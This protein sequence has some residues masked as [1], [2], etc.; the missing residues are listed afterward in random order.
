MGVERSE[1]TGA[2][3]HSN[4]LTDKQNQGGC[5]SRKAPEGPRSRIRAGVRAHV[6]AAVIPRGYGQ[7]VYSGI[8][9]VGP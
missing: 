7:A 8:P 6:H 2:G 4:N 9:G 3:P 5:P 1:G